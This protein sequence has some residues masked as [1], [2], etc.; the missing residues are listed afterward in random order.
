[1]VRNP[2][3]TTS[4][5]LRKKQHFRTRDSAHRYCC[6]ACSDWPAAVST[7]PRKKRRETGGAGC[8]TEVVL[9][10]ELALTTVL[11]LIF[12]KALKKKMIPMRAGV[13]ITESAMM[14][15]FLHTLLAEE[16]RAIGLQGLKTPREMFNILKHTGDPGDQ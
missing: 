8:Y 9:A 12:Q 3:G 11:W 1:M 6:P 7:H 16:L 4:T 15:C 10:N 5:I 2:P 14:D 13:R